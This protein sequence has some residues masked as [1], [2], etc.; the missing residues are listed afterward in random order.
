M[1]SR[2][3]SGYR[4]MRRSFRWA[5]WAVGAII[6]GVLGV[7]G[8]TLLDVDI[9]HVSIWPARSDVPRAARPPAETP[10]NAD[11]QPTAQDVQPTA[12]TETADDIV[13]P[14][15]PQE[16]ALLVES[17]S[18]TQLL[19]T[20]DQAERTTGPVVAAEVHVDTVI[21]MSTPVFVLTNHLRFGPEGALKAPEIV[22]FATHVAGGVLDASGAPGPPGSSQSG[23]GSPGDSGGPGLPGGSVFVAAGRVDDTRIDA[24]GGTGGVG[25]TGKVGGA[26]RNGSCRGFGDWVGAT[27][28]GR[29]GRGGDGGL[30]GPGGE[31]AILVPA[32]GRNY[33]RPRVDGGAG[34]GGGDGGAGGRGG[35]GCTGLGGSQSGHPSGPGGGSGSPGG[36][37]ADGNVGI[38]DIRFTQVKTALDEVGRVLR[39][40]GFREIETLDAVRRRLL[41]S[42]D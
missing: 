16:P 34:G 4:S 23:A 41:V 31:V 5:L 21:E 39:D 22:I 11:A 42:P 3:V 8:L 27:D 6:A 1:T 28:G 20:Q 9:E 7:G 13:E 24:S 10:P 29:G 12:E 36:R 15:P 17:T 14:P 37:G 38:R 35:S 33:E 32:L 19:L 26:G 30:G 18:E 2:I 40:P 25:E